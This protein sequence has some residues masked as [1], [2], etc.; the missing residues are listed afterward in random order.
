MTEGSRRRAGLI[1]HRERLRF[2]IFPEE[3]RLIKRELKTGTEANKITTCRGLIGKGTVTKI[4]EIGKQR[5][6][7]EDPITWDEMKKRFK[8]Q[9]ELNSAGFPVVRP[10]SIERKGN[11]IIWNEEEIRG[12][13][14]METLDEIKKLKRTETA[15]TRTEEIN[16]KREEFKYLQKNYEKQTQEFLNKLM[17]VDEKYLELINFEPI[18]CDLG[19]SNAIWNGKKFIFTDILITRKTPKRSKKSQ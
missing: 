9:R 17:K 18:L 3:V 8:F 19:Y 13:T 2:K 6:K 11:E 15:A 5:E 1:K 4:Y 16:K 10:I 14:L 7:I 12:T